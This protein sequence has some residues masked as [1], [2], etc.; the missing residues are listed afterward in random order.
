MAVP[1]LAQDAGAALHSAEDVGAALAQ[2]GRF[3]PAPE[4]DARRARAPGPARLAR[5]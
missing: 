4:E 1:V 3:L 2:A 5:H